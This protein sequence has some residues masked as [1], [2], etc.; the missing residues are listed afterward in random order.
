LPK[1][2][3]QILQCNQEL[4][5]IVANIST[6]LIKSDVLTTEVK[7][8]LNPLGAVLHKLAVLTQLK[9]DIQLFW[10]FAKLQVCFL[11]SYKH[12]NI[13]QSN[14]VNEMEEI[15]L[16]LGSSVLF[17]NQYYYPKGNEKI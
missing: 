2:R 7:A 9:P 10:N 14:N 6:V 4:D 12:L 13:R 11:R 16:R 5:D 15:R 17:F 3:E 1:R 8:E